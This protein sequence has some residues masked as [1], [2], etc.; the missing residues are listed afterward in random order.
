MFS[1]FSYDLKRIIDNSK[2]EMKSMGH[3]Y[4]GTEHFLLSVLKIDNDIKE[5]LNSYGITYDY[6]KERIIDNLGVGNEKESLYIFTPLFKKIIEESM[7]LTNELNLKEVEVSTVFKV[8]LDEAEGVAYRLLCELN[9]NVDELYDSINNININKTNDVFGNIGIDLTEKAKEGLIFQAI[10]RDK[11]IEN[12]I[13]ILLRKN[14]KNPILIGDAGVGKTAIVESLAYKIVNNDVP[15]NLLNKKIISISM[16][17]LISGTKYRG[18]FE[19]KL[20]NII[21]ELEN[22]NN[23]ILFIDEI[24]TLVGAGGAEGAIDA[25][26]ILKPYLARDN[27]TIIGATTTQEYRKYIEDDKALSRRFQKVYIDEPD[28][29]TLFN[30]LSKVKNNYEKYHNVVISDEVIKYIINISGKYLTYKKEPDRSIDILDEVSSMVFSKVDNIQLK[31][32][33][34]RKKLNKIKNIKQSL[35]INNKFDEA[36][37]YRI[38][39][40]IIESKINKNYL[41]KVNNNNPRVITENDVNELISKKLNITLNNCKV[42]KNVLEIQKKALKA[43]YVNMSNEI[44]L[45]INNMKD[46]FIC[47]KKIDKPIS[48]LI[49]TDNNKEI[50]NIVKKIGEMFFNNNLIKINLSEYKDD[51]SISK[52]VGALPGYIGFNNKN[53]TFEILKEKPVSIVFFE[54][55]DQTCN[56]IKNFIKSIIEKGFFIDSNG[57]KISFMTSLIVVLSK[58]C[59]K[60]L[61]GF[62]N[63][64]NINEQEINNLVSKIININKKVYV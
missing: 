20:L 12:V 53:N 28:C 36:L 61:I 9:I 50:N 44:D 17:S 7:I 18:E 42:I 45:I 4:I 13:E 22:N 62:N 63:T 32:N 26:N 48:Y 16:A 29:K 41:K 10:G 57:Y 56:T 8:M 49:S 25:S 19:E 35:I 11:E 51:Q 54:N 38:K 59:N 15:N 47:N 55:Y 23:I 30:I 6:F 52:M 31:N 46:I 34:L 39:E 40:K 21:N 5:L 37:S 43:E 24:H 33:K 3:L 14:K 27:L 64:I 60:Q 1:N 58:E 2:K